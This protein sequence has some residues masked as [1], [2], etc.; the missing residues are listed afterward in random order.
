MRRGSNETGAQRANPLTER[1]FTQHRRLK[2]DGWHHS[3][4]SNPSR[5]PWPTETFPPH[6]AL[7]TWRAKPEA[8]G[9]LRLIVIILGEKDIGCFHFQRMEKCEFIVFILSSIVI[10]LSPVCT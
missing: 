7:A 8:V 6:S 4:H 2:P 3:A 10:K 1:R 9:A 5:P